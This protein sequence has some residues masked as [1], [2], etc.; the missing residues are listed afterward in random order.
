MEWLC[1]QPS[2]GLFHHRGVVFITPIILVTGEEYFIA[3]DHIVS[4]AR[5]AVAG[6]DFTRFT[7]PRLTQYFA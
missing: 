3:R 6:A 4:A 5:K 2:G 1:A 7:E